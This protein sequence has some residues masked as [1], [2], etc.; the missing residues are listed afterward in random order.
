MGRVGHS[1]PLHVG[2]PLHGM[3]HGLGF[4]ILVGHTTWKGRTPIWKSFPML[5]LNFMK[6]NLKLVSVMH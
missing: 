2:R 1:V 6:G 4:L 3:F 5:L